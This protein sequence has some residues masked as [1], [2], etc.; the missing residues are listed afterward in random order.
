MALPHTLR[1]ALAALTLTVLPPAATAQPAVAVRPLPPPV[2]AQGEAFRSVD[3]YGTVTFS[4]T[5]PAGR[6][7]KL[8]ELKPLAGTVEGT[9]V[10]A[11]PPAAKPAA[12]VPPEPARRDAEPPRGPREPRG[13]SLE[14]FALIRRGMT[15][16][17]VLI[18]AGPPDHETF[19]HVHGLIQ[20]SWF[21]F[22]TPGNPWNTIIRLRGGIVIETERVRRL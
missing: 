9:R 4:Q 14:T 6:P 19:E 18:R 1:A 15:E 5:P 13:M 12:R 7:S 17:E 10:P 11:A 3:E 2:P 20:K 21:Y 8:V 22:P 16:G